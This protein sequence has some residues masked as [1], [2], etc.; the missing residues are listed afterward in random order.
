MTAS[1]VKDLINPDGKFERE[2]LP[3]GKSIYD[4]W[5]TISDEGGFL[6]DGYGKDLVDCGVQVITM[7]T[8]VNYAIYEMECSG[9]VATEV[10]EDGKGGYI[11]DFRRI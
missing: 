4:C 5:F 3:N 10:T 6:C 2:I 9:K 11:I 7:A 8:L 1:T